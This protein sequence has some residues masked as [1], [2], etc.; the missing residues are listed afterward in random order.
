MPELCD[1][2]HSIC[3]QVYVVSLAV[4]M[5]TCTA[6]LCVQPQDVFWGRCS[7]RKRKPTFYVDYLAIFLLPKATKYALWNKKFGSSLVLIPSFFHLKPFR[8]K[9]KQNETKSCKIINDVSLNMKKTKVRE[10]K[11][12][13]RESST[14]SN[15]GAKGKCLCKS[16]LSVYISLSDH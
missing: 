12:E 8:G 10:R 15:G 13:G 7:F 4:W 3:W 5:N 2:C 11:K 1:I 14:S 6:F 9:R 16:S